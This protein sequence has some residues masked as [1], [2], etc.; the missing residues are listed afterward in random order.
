MAVVDAED[1]LEVA[2]PKDEDAVEAVGAERSHPAF[3]ISG[4]FHLRPHAP[5]SACSVVS[6]SEKTGFAQFD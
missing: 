2:A 3:G 1:V 4:D 5:A 6:S